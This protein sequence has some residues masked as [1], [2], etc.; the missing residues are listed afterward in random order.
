[1]SAP[2]GAEIAP[3]DPAPLPCAAGV[4]WS[5]AAAIRLPH[6]AHSVTPASS[7][8]A[9]LVKAVAVRRPSLTC[10]PRSTGKQPHR[11]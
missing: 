8:V 3:G 2:L 7:A 6:M 9:S 1:M 11:E 5:I 4:Y 10:C